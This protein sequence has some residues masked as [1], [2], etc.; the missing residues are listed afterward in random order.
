M[1]EKLISKPTYIT[2]LYRSGVFKYKGGGS[3][4]WSNIGKSTNRY[5][6]DNDHYLDELEMHAR[7]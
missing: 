1:A 2:K 4:S 6:K 5:N 7:A 3:Y